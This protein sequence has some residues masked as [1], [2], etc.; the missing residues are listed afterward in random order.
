MLFMRPVVKARV[1][2]IKRSAALAA[3]WEK[4]GQPL[5]EMFV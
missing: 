5:L 2:T 1:E 4:V 3:L